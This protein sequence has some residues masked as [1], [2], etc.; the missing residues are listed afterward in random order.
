LDTETDEI[1]LRRIELLIPDELARLVDAEYGALVRYVAQRYLQQADN[2][3]L[4]PPYFIVELRREVRTLP[5]ARFLNEKEIDALV[6]MVV[7]GV[8]ARLYENGRG[9]G[10]RGGLGF[11]GDLE[12][13]PHRTG[14]LSSF[15]PK[16]WPLLLILDSASTQLF[17]HSLS[18]IYASVPALG[19]WYSTRT[20]GA[21]LCRTNGRSAPC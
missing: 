10:G 14:F 18:G 4:S 15:P 8:R 16:I 17:L 20:N 7:A 5:S 19:A 3:V 21:E 1:E 11:L 12:G 2:T 6:R 13:A 9:A